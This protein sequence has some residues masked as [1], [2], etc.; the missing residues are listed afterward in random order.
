MTKEEALVKV[1]GYL[2]DYLPLDSADEIDEIIKALEQPSRNCSSCKHSDNGK[3]AYTE[4]CHECMWDNKYDKQPCDKC[5]YSTKDGYCQY[6]DIAETIPTKQ[7]PCEACREQ[8]L[9]HLEKEDWA[10]TVNCVMNMPFINKPCISE[11]VCHE[12][13]MQVLDKIRAEIDQKQYDFMA[14][15]DYDEGIRFGLMLAYQIIDKYK[16]ESEV[17]RNDNK[18]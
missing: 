9:K 11:G 17:N 6:D 18:K 5:V 1:R 14:D 15:K 4:E 7:P 3:C 12:D 2:T 8:V 16:A 13:K 10:D